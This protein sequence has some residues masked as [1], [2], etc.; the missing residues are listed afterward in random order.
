MTFTEDDQ[1]SGSE[2]DNNPALWQWPREELQKFAADVEDGLRHSSSKQKRLSLSALVS[3]L[4]GIPEE[5]LKTEGFQEARQSLK[6]LSRLPREGKVRELLLKMQHLAKKAVARQ[7][8]VTADAPAAA[9]RKATET[10]AKAAA[11]EAKPKMDEKE[12]SSEAEAS[13]RHEGE[14]ENR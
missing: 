3:L 5:L 7:A 11:S 13:E 6:Q 14:E 12:G 9:A 8:A 1:E 4:D 2:Q 10:T